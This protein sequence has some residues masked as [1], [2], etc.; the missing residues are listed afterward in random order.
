MAVFLLHS[1]RET[2]QISLWNLPETWL[3]HHP[4]SEINLLQKQVTTNHH[5]KK[6]PDC[7]R[8]QKTGAKAKHPNTSLCHQ[9]TMANLYSAFPR[10]N[11]PKTTNLKPMM[12]VFVSLLF[13][14]KPVRQCP[15]HPLGAYQVDIMWIRFCLTESMKVVETP[16]VTHPQPRQSVHLMLI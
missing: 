3:L 1:F 6:E 12:S 2:E 15:G 8:L 4:G 5:Q 10:P 11:D 9:T 13:P 7:C 16:E 14:F